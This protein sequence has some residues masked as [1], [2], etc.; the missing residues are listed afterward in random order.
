ATP[1]GR[2]LFIANPPPS[3]KIL[4]LDRH[5]I[6]AQ[7]ILDGLEGKADRDGYEPDGEVTVN[8]LVEYMGKAI[9]ELARRH[10]KTQE[11]KEEQAVVLGTRTVNYPIT[12][13]PAVSAKVQDR[14][15]KFEKIARDGQLSDKLS[16]EGRTLLARM[17]KLEAYRKLRQE[18]Q[19][20]AD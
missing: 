5:D 11:D 19:R 3:F 9:P 2:T 18:Y 6:F 7:V 1:R 14:L 12:R 20:L 8:E 15:E 16:K 4:D 10:G 17:P 13:N